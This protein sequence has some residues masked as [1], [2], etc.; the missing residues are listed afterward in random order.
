M[1]PL[2]CAITAFQ[3]PGQIGL[4]DIAKSFQDSPPRG[5]EPHQFFSF[6]NISTNMVAR[7]IQSFG[8]NGPWLAGWLSNCQNFFSNLRT[9]EMNKCWKFQA[10][11][12]IHVWFR[13]KRLKICCNQW[14][15]EV[16]IRP[17]CT[18]GVH[19]LQQISSYLAITQTRIIGSSW[20]FQH[21]FT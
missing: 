20:N 8:Q 13:A 4:R 15:P 5:P 16:Q 18:L 19:W 2:P 7:G 21:L 1:G 11:I 14:T 10:D 6:W 12:L 3:R 17:W 9:H